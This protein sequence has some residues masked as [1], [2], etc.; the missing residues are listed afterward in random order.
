MRNYENLNR[1][2]ENTLAPRAHYIPYDSLE[3]ALEGDKSKSDF[4]MLLN[5]EWDFKYFARDIDCPDTIGEWDKVKV[6]SCWQTTGYEK[7]YYTNVNYPYPVDPPYVPDDNPLGVY[8][9]F[10]NIDADKAAK[11]NYIV[12][13]GVAPC[14]ELYVNGEY[15]GFSTVSHSTSEFKIK[16]REGENEIIAK[17]Y[18]YCFASYLEDQDFFRNNGIFRDVY[19]L[20]RNGGHVHD[21]QIGFDSKNI[22]CDEN[23]RVYDA[24]GKET[25][26]SNP[27]L[28]NAERPYL[29]TAVVEKAGEFIPFKIG[30][31]E[32][33]ISDK[34]E[35]LINGV[36]VKLKG[37][38][39]H[40]THPFDGYAMSCDFMR[41]ELLKMKELNINAIRTSHYPP[42]P[43]FLELCD[44]LGFYVID[45]A[46]IETHGFANRN[47]NGWGYDD[48]T[49][50]PC[51]NPQWHDV[52]VDRA[53]R[54]F[55]RDK[56]HTCVVMWSMGNESNYGENFVAMIKFIKERQ[57]SYSGINRLIH[58]ENVYNNVPVAKA[59]PNDMA[60]DP[61][62]LDV[63]SRMYWTA[64]DIFHYIGVTGDKR[65]FFLCEYSH[66][67]G[68]GPGDLMDYW[69]VIEKNEQL[70]GGCI[71][72]WAD[73]VAPM[74]DGHLGYGGDF[75]EETHDANFCCDGL[76][77]G[78]RSF[79][80]GSYEAKYAYQPLRSEW[81][82]GVLTLINKFDF[83]DFTDYDFTLTVTSDAKI[84]KT[85]KLK[86]SAKPHTSE[87]ISVDVSGIDG[88]YGVY[89]N[90]SMKDKNGFEVAHVQ[91]E[92]APSKPVADGN[93]AV[94]IK[95]DGEYAIISGSGFT[96]KFNT[97]Y[98]YIE[99]LDGYLKAPMKLSI[100]RA[101]TDNDRVIKSR[102]LNN[103]Y[104]KAHNKVYEVKID[105]NSIIVRGG[106]NSVSRMNFIDYTVVYTFF[107][108]GRI[109]VDFNGQFDQ[110][111]TF[112]P[113]LGFE[114]KT[115][116]T[117]FE[118]FGC[119]P[120][121]SYIDMRNASQM[122]MYHS[123]AADEY[124]DYIK[125][126]EHGNHYNTKYLK[127]GGYTFVSENGFEFAVSEYSKEEL[128]AKKHN[129]ELEKDKHTN[130]RIDYK[131]SGIGSGSCGPQLVEAYQLNDK[132]IAFKFSIIKD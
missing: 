11:E 40:D 27:I 96:Y 19:I 101:P 88:Q 92:I 49:M 119:G 4:Y 59:Y 97:H 114:F 100:W 51:K 8:R 113:R 32:Q 38:N 14:F 67:M 6:P 50:W 41:S 28:W 1:P 94:K 122:G 129:F 83:T 43:A 78:D 42:Q 62:E 57:N 107:A 18:K 26:L 58:Y 3:K 90:V 63:V 56:N 65:P 23:Y 15:I 77:F 37:V 34:G 5:G 109:D 68:N 80:A 39:H 116:E 91:H 98:G 103:N 99:E 64:S 12:F 131:V 89:L 95:A 22:Y 74:S 106:L 81:N 36:S 47:A 7:P 35:L 132:N 70:I 44:E 17:V 66:A 126:Q 45:E 21:V 115:D 72:E 128:S 20:S 108:D 117:D 46:D 53:Q 71:W 125:P 55:E 30:L 60:K 54:L 61:D 10:V 24:D 69:K 13:E 120:Y 16:L 127:L 2:H 31:R 104:D 25:D 111:R 79:K 87:D 110:T 73:H 102:W 75:G 121:E 33:S 130:V 112:L 118:Y 123:T 93:G 85:E 52:F 105:G 9:R 76:V 82:N 48:S 86:L 124:V 29:Y 84:V